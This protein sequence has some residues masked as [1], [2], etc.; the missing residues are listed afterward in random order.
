MNHLSL[1]LAAVCKVLSRYADMENPRE[2]NRYAWNDLRPVQTL[3][4]VGVRADS[5]RR[6][7]S[8]GFEAPAM[9]ISM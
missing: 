5:V 6:Q 8:P 1:Y 3:C 9:Q 4:G 7:A 2:Q